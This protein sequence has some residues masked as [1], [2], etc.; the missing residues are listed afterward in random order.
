MS[1]S[2]SEFERIKP[3]KTY[4]EIKSLIDKYSENADSTYIRAEAI[5]KDLERLKKIFLSGE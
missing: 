3:K 4:K 5:V 1:T 2:I